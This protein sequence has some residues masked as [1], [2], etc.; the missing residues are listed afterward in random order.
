MKVLQ[1]IRRTFL[2]EYLKYLIF[3]LDMDRDS[4][5][6]LSTVCTPSTQ[7][8]KSLALSL[9]TLRMEFI[10]HYNLELGPGKGVPAPRC[11]IPLLVADFQRITAYAGVL[12]TRVSVHA[13]RFGARMTALACVCIAAQMLDDFADESTS[14][15]FEGTGVGKVVAALFKAMDYSAWVDN[16]SV[17]KWKATYLNA[18][19]VVV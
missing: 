8:V 15:I 9:R 2:E 12:M 14:G 10:K 19:P 16:E 4:R 6:L 11:I 7:L 17:A 3:L 18:H 13:R 1:L 5:A